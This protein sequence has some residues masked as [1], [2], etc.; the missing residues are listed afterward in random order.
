MASPHESIPID[1]QFLYTVC[2]CSKGTLQVYP[3]YHYLL[4]TIT[5]VSLAVWTFLYKKSFILQ[6]LSGIENNVEQ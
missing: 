5:S 4:V 2:S 3:K 6:I 1:G